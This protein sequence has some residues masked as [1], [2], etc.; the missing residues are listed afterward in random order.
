M[1]IIK[2]NGSLFFLC[3]YLYFW[4]LRKQ[5]FWFTKRKI[6]SNIVRIKY[7]IIGRNNYID[8]GKNTIAEK[9]KIHI[10][11]NNNT[12]K[13]GDNCYIGPDCLIYIEGNNC[14]ITIEDDTTSTRNNEFNVQEDYTQ[15]YIGMDCMFSNNII[16]RTS[17]SHP[18]FDLKD[19]KRLNEA[20]NIYIGNHVWIAPNTKIMKGS[21]INDGCIIG[22]DTTINKEVPK[23]CL[24]VGRPAKVLRN[25]VYWTREK[26]F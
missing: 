18:Y 6:R 24:I 16:V 4:Y 25:N 23:N 14:N 11:G 3:R 9:L 13:I 10:R 12:L 19:G 20:Q 7:D 21:R 17:D 2:C 1:N 15:I 22:S 5:S 8:L 26:L